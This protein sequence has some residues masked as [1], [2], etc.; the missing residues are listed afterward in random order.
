M[1]QIP[2]SYYLLLSAALFSIGLAVMIVKRHIILILMG[3]ELML[4]AVN[5]NFVAFGRNDPSQTGQ[6]MSLFVLVVAAAEAVVVLA[7]LL[8]AYKHYGSVNMDDFADM[9][10]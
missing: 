7:I 3:L 1:E 4:N 9:E 2:L 8:L 10:G 6:F 5:I